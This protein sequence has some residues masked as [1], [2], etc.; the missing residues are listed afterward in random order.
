MFQIASQKTRKI[1]KR[2]FLGSEFTNIDEKKKNFDSL[3]RFQRLLILESAKK[4]P[5]IS[6]E[7]I[8]NL[9]I[10]M[11]AQQFHFLF[12]HSK[13]NKNLRRLTKILII[14]VSSFSRSS[15][16]VQIL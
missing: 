11:F 3:F 9:T 15:L 7:F 4:T 2:N 5:K 12:V 1:I 8:Q 14:C 16:T 13:N 6:S 10:F